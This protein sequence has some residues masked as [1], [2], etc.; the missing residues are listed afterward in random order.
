M[1]WVGFVYSWLSKYNPYGVV[2]LSGVEDPKKKAKRAMDNHGA[3]E[4]VDR[5]DRKETSVRRVL[6]GR[7]YSPQMRY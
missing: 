6:E 3:P 5:T 1:C 7:R 2:N 4:N